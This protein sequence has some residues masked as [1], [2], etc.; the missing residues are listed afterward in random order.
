M[1]PNKTNKLFLLTAFCTLVESQDHQKA[2]DLLGVGVHQLM[3]FI[4]ELE[5]ILGI[6]LFDPESMTLKLSDEGQLVYSSF[7]QSFVMYQ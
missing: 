3:L 7:S 5:T 4:R 2:S 6:Q 1:N